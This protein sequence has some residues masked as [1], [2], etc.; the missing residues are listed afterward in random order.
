MGIKEHHQ[1]EGRLCII[2]QDLAGNRVERRQVNNLITNAGRTLLAHYLIGKQEG[3][4]QLVIAVGRGDETP[5]EQ[6][7]A[8]RGPVAQINV[9]PD[10]ISTEYEDNEV[11]VIL[12]ATLAPANPGEEQML[13]E[14]GIMVGLPDGGK[15]LYNRTVFPVITRTDSLRITLT[16][17]LLF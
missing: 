4:P 6:D 8:L 15:V 14:A 2:T 10:D 16:W 1:L 11:K 12:T 9:N 3:R 7:T 5:G 13:R 17:E